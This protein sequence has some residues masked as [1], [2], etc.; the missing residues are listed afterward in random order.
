M[1]QLG[2]DDMLTVSLHRRGPTGKTLSTRVYRNVE[3]KCTPAGVWL[4]SKNPVFKTG[5][6]WK[7]VKFHARFLKDGKLTIVRY[8]EEEYLKMLKCKDMEM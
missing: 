4:F 1:E 2:D 5:L 8:E 7:E 3:F 6:P